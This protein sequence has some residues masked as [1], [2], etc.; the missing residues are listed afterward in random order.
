MFGLF[1][2]SKQE[3]RTLKRFPPVPVWRPEER[4]SMDRLI[5]RMKYYTN[6]KKDFA[7]FEHGSMVILPDGLSDSGIVSHVCHASGVLRSSRHAPVAHGRR[8]YSHKV[9]P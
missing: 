2:K 4:Q 1:K 5:D 6:D 8:K 7:V 3:P 9:Q